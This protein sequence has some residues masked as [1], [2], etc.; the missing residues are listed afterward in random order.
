MQKNNPQAN[1]I[2]IAIQSD[3]RSFGGVIFWSERA[4]TI[5][6]PGV[7]LIH[8]KPEKWSLIEIILESPASVA[9]ACRSAPC[10][11][12]CRS[13]DPVDINFACRLEDMLKLL[14][15]AGGDNMIRAL[16]AP[17]CRSLVSSQVFRIQ[18]LSYPQE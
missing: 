15:P 11:Y 10:L 2:I 16:F 6:E 5:K 14:P 7:V 1:G 3:Y 13:P 4:C 17:S 8:H 9:N 12:I 18:G